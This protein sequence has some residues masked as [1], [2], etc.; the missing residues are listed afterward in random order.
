MFGVQW[1]AT[2]IFTK[3][4]RVAI[5]LANFELSPGLLSDGHAIKW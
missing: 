3:P 5:M 2:L 4:N 1:L